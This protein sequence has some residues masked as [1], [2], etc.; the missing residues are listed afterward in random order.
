[1]IWGTL[2]RPLHS[3]QACRPCKVDGD[4]TT[5]VRWTIS[6]SNRS[7]LVSRCWLNKINNRLRRTSLRTRKRKWV[8]PKNEFVCKMMTRKYAGLSESSGDWSA[9]FHLLFLTNRRLFW[10]T[11]IG[12]ISLLALCL[13]VA[14]ERAQ[15]RERNPHRG[16][17]MLALICLIVEWT[18]R[19]WWIHNGASGWANLAIKTLIGGI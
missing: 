15:R 16:A 14:R 13:L 1:M 17:S 10:K 7:H 3:T 9:S 12:A 8:R 6:G 18:A 5:C 2:P 11:N 4:V 19:S